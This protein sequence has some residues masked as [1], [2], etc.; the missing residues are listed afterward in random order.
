MLVSVINLSD[1]KKNCV[2]CCDN[3]E[4][5]EKVINLLC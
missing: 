4:P 3:Y 5:N 2:I 1:E